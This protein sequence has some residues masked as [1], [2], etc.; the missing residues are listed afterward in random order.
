MYP[1]SD[2]S[3]LD[4]MNATHMTFQLGDRIISDRHLKLAG[5]LSVCRKHYQKAGFLDDNQPDSPLAQHFQSSQDA[6]RRGA[7]DIAEVEIFNLA[8]KLMEL[9]QVGKYDPQLLRRIKQR[10]RTHRLDDYL[11]VQCEIAVASLLLAKRFQFTCP[12]PPDF[13]IKVEGSEQPA[14][15]EC[16]SVHI[17]TDSDRELIYKVGSAINAKKKKEYCRADSALVVDIT[18]VMYH[19]HKAGWNLNPNAIKENFADLASDSGFGAVLILCEV[20]NL[21]KGR[22]E[23]LYSR[24]AI[25]SP[26]VELQTVLDQCFTDGE[27]FV[28]QAVFPRI[29]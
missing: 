2:G 19:S 4:L 29:S 27:Y 18:N 12:D 10:L 26:S 23:T 22:M 3:G 1:P 21:E 28:T 6:L 20:G 13:Q 25:E 16:T 9:G 11:G 8:A 17:E 15:I 5:R 7:L 24:L 14:C